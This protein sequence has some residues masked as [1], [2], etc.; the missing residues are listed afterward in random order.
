MLKIPY[1]LS[2]FERI[3]KA[4]FLYVDKTHFIEKVEAFDYVMHLR[5]RRFGKSL[6]LDMLDH[7]YDVANVDK[8]DE[9]FGG[10]FVH[11]NPTDDR[12]SYYILRLNFSGIENDEEEGLKKGFLRRVTIDAQRFINRYNLNINLSQLETPAGVLDTL[13]EGF[14]AL[15]LKHK[16]Y[17]L[18]DEYDPFTNAVL[19]GNGEEFLAALKR[20]GFVRSF[21]EVIKERA[22]SGVVERLFMTGVMS[23]T[24]DSMTSGFNIATNLTTNENFSDMMGFTDDEVKDLLKLSYSNSIQPKKMVKL[25][26][27]EQVTTYEIFKD[28][29]NGY[30]FS[31]RSSI[32]VFNSTLI[33]YYLQHYLPK[34]RF[35]E[36]L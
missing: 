22:G 27:E 8:F 9:L 36:V 35:L 21:Y 3:R 7:Y 30:L 10:L 13:L 11:E 20:G 6:F 23:V 15:N 31:E 34:K 5:P 26:D 2:N 12:H 29:Y 4:N 33:M 24:L 18:I 16:V 25:T 14:E 1:G 19:S 32:K 28:N 17:I